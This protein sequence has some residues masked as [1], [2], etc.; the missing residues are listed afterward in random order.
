MTN[1]DIVKGNEANITDF[2]FVSELSE[3][4]YLTNYK[5]TNQNDR[6][7]KTVHTTIS[8]I[9]LQ[10]STPENSQHMFLVTLVL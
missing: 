3:K 9:T 6:T 7:K 2:K 5:E 10:S 1:A 8:M 4:K